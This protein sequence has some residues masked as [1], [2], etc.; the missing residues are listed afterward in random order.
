[1]LK[2]S[3]R[4]NT[5]IPMTITAAGSRA[6]RVLRVLLVD[7][8]AREERQHRAL[9]LR[10]S[11]KAGRARPA[12][13]VAEYPSARV[14]QVA[15]GAECGAALE[16]RRGERRSAVAKA[17]R[18]LRTEAP[19]TPW[20]G[21]ARGTDWR[22]RRFP[23]VDVGHLHAY[24]HPAQGRD[25]PCPPKGAQSHK[26]GGEQ[27]LRRH[28]DDVAG[29]PPA[30]GDA[31]AR[32]N[33]EEAQFSPGGH[34]PALALVLVVCAPAPRHERGRA[35]LLANGDGRRQ[36]SAHVDA[37]GRWAAARRRLISSRRYPA[38]HEQQPGLASDGAPRRRGRGGDNGGAAR[39]RDRGAPRRRRGG[40][41]GS[42]AAND[43]RRR[44]RAAAAR[45][46]VVR[47]INHYKFFG[48]MLK[49]VTGPW[50]AGPS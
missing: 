43:G 49:P 20:I 38:P 24:D 25:A 13:A 17:V 32:L 27:Q 5:V 21:A 1:M 23:L 14:A 10:L 29:A 44:G 11:G 8:A 12:V 3:P 46:C 4:I 45:A 35:R 39:A 7:S 2:R 33:A 31:R 16:E 22:S 36:G 18:W 9:S 15:D 48:L 19:P 6:D 26:A 50:G 47:L 28:R 30:A 37:G 34:Q 40:G 42:V 41:R